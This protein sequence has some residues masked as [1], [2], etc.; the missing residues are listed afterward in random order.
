MLSES[1]ASGPLMPHL[2]YFRG[3]LEVGPDKLL[4]CL[5]GSALCTLV[6]DQ[7]KSS[8]RVAEA[9]IASKRIVRSLHRTFPHLQHLYLRYALW[10]EVMC[11]LD[12][13]WIE[14]HTCSRCNNA[15][16]REPH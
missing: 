12:K 14:R 10:R 9:Y 7:P 11:G 4:A 6:L 3:I 15:K 13:L 8:R 5:A 16:R 1:V 2:T